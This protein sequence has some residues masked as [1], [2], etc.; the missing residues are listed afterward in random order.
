MP[1]RRGIT[2]IGLTLALMSVTAVGVGAQTETEDGEPAA[3]TYVTGTLGAPAQI[4]SGRTSVTD[5]VT[6]RRGWLF[7]DVPIETSDPRLNGLI[8]TSANGD[9]RRVTGTTEAVDLQ[10]SK[11][12]IANDDGSWLGQGTA[13]I[14]LEGGTPTADLDTLLLTGEGAYE[15]LSAYLLFDFSESPTAVEGVVFAGEMTPAPGLPPAE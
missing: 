14:H 4:T 1:T 9:E 6:Q 13:F 3:T 11:Y 2:I 10:S 15:G 7:A 12:R 8:T 5:G